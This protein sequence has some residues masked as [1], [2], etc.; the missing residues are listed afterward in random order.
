MLLHIFFALV[1][2]GGGCFVVSPGVR[3]KISAIVVSVCE[4]E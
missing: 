3:M 1:V 4:E 2:S